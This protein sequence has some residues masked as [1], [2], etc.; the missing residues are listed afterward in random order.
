MYFRWNP[1][2]KKSGI[3]GVLYAQSKRN[4]VV[5]KHG[6]LNTFVRSEEK[7]EQHRW[8]NKKT[9]FET[10]LPVREKS[11]FYFYIRMFFDFLSFNNFFN[12]CTFFL[13]L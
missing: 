5:S 7:E 12:I 4:R 2:R 1:F 9:Y 11:N 10:F 8:R 6:K 3:M 13:N